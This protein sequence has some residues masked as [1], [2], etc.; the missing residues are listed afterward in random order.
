MAKYE[1]SRLTSSFYIS[2]ALLMI[3]AVHTQTVFA[4]LPPAAYREMLS[5]CLLAHHSLSV[6]GL[7]IALQSVADLKRC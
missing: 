3:F 4:E 6:W 5:L 2:V 1:R 7:W